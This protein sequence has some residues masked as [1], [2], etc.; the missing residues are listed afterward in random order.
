MKQSCHILGS[1]LLGMA[2][3][4]SVWANEVT[5]RS[6]LPDYE[7][8]MLSALPAAPKARLQEC[9]TAPA[10]LSAGK[11]LEAAGWQVISEISLGD[12]ALVTFAASSSPGERG[13]CDVTNGNLGIFEAERLIGLYWSRVK[14]NT[15]FGA[16]STEREGVIDLRSSTFPATPIAEILRIDDTFVLRARPST[17]AGCT[18]KV[19]VP[20][21]WQEP[22]GKMRDALIALGWAPMSPSAQD[23]VSAD[24]QAQG[25][26]E[27][28][29]CTGTGYNYCSYEYS[30]PEAKLRVISM[31]ELGPDHQ[32]AM[33]DYDLTCQDVAP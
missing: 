24:M 16:L 26:P 27:T 20:Q 17:L 11:A 29:S 33:I 32:P 6:E 30:K 23:P 9:R 2:L 18:G 14:E 4:A 28:E 22:V 10:T 31:G 12:H 7:A 5:L 1:I 3:P 8:S 25:F 21:L 19:E 15:L 13:L